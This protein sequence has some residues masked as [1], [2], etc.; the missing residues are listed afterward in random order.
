MPWK[1]TKDIIDNGR[2]A[3]NNTRS[4]NWE[5][6]HHHL[7]LMMF[8]LL[9]GDGEIYF[10]GI[11]TLDEEFQPL[12]DFGRSYGCTSIQYKEQGKWKEL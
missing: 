4:A 5:Y 3:A 2:A 1:I 9:D 6:R 10:E 12:D 7:D 11:A 8:R